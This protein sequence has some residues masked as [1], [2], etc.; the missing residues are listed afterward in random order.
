MLHMEAVLRRLHMKIFVDTDDDTRLA[1]R[2]RR[3][4]SA[5]GRD[6]DGVIKQYT[7]FVKPSFDS[8]VLPSKKRADVVIPCTNGMYPHSVADHTK[9]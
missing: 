8:F 3:D 6:V 2:I 4:V 5:R 1:R 7:R 9:S